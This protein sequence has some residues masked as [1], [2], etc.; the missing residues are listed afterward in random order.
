MRLTMKKQ[1]ILIVTML[2]LLSIVV[3]GFAL[4]NKVLAEE[5]GFTG[6]KIEQGKY[7]YY[8]DGKVDKKTKT[9]ARVDGKGPW[10]YVKEGTVNWNKNGMVGY[11]GNLVYIK[12]GKWN[13]KFSG[14]YKKGGV[15][16]LVKNGIQNKTFKGLV[17]YGNDWLYM[18]NGVWNKK[19]NGKA[20]I[21]G[22]PRKVKVKKGKV[23]S[24]Q[25][26]PNA[27]L[28]K[29]AEKVIKKNGINTLQKAFN[30]ACCPYVSYDR[31][32]RLGVAHFAAFGLK[33]HYGNCYVMA[34]IFCVLARELGYEA[35]QITGYVGSKFGGL[36]PHSWVEVKANGHWYVCDPDQTVEGGMYA[37]LI[38]YGTPGSW[39]GSY[40]SRMRD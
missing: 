19:F 3:S 5:A 17:R 9:L 40:Y 25:V 30:W 11:K 8:T 33:N 16:Y 26:P 39:V 1:G 18:E 2:L 35:Y 21:K 27:K 24:G 20:S 13:K 12:D 34:A 38:Q 15:I 4:P 31:D 23:K 22:F 14:L 29:M 37:F 32:G 36:T 6:L 28:A 7:V 10:Y